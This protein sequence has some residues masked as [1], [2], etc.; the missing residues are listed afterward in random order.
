M[1]EILAIVLISV[2]CVGCGSSKNTSSNLTGN[3]QITANST[4]FGL[5]ATGSGALQ[6]NGSAITGQIT[7]S[8]TPCAT[9]ATL[10]GTSSG[11]AVTLQ[12]QEGSQPVNL[13]GTTN[14]GFTSMSGGYTAPSG[15]CTNGDFGT[16][17]ATKT[18]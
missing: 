14:P 13:T 1:K 9:S 18:S 6:Q 12:L 8:G 16:W 11:T 17:T 4:A 7:L 3:W 10:S 2:F 5:T 15:G